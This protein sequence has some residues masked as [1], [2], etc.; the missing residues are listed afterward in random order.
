MVKLPDINSSGLPRRNI[1][2]TKAT[3]IAAGIIIQVFLLSLL[4]F[5]IIPPP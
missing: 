5:K 3:A 2:I 4:I 1:A